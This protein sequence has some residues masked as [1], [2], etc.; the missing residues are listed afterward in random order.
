MD[1]YIDAI[2]IIL[3]PY[4]LRGGLDFEGAGGEGALRGIIGT[5]S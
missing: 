5:R 1:T 4:V 2:T 3:Y